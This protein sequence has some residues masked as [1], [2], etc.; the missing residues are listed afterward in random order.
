MKKFCMGVMCPLGKRVC[1]QYCDERCT[2]MCEDNPLICD[3]LC[4][5]DELD[6]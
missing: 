2:N 6:D 4:E 1:C 5:E 3:D